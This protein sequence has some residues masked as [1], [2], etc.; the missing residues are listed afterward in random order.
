LRILPISTSE[1]TYNA[2]NL[3]YHSYQPGGQAGYKPQDG[4]D[5]LS[6]GDNCLRDAIVLQ[7]LGVNTI[8][9]YNI[10]PD[11]NHDLCMSIFNYA[12]IYV[13]LDVNSP[14]VGESIDRSA[15]WTTYHEGYLT[16][17][18]K[19][20]EAFKDFPNVLALFAGNEII[21]DMNTTMYNPMY[22]RAVQRDMKQYIAK[23]ASRKIPGK[24]TTTSDNFSL[25]Y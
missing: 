23:H 18:F 14:L 10:D 5:A 13:I 20:I 25:R 3:I 19:V 12:G 6:N 1:I 9:I 17:V 8:R 4:Q 2:G 16:R 11:L 21:N 15:P 7:G 22:I 24:T